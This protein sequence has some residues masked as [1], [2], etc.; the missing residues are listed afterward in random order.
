MARAGVPIAAFH[1]PASTEKSMKIGIL[2]E[3]PLVFSKEAALDVL[4]SKNVGKYSQRLSATVDFIKKHGLQEK[5]ADLIKI[6]DGAI[7]HQ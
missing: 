5:Y 7:Q 1:L 3:V 4:K 2:E 6:I